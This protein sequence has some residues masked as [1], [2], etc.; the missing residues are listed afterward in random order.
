MVACSNVYL[1]IANH[2]LNNQS[3]VTEIIHT[4]PHGRNFFKY[5]T[6][7]WKIQLSFMHLLHFWAYR[8]LSIMPKILQI[9]VRIQMQTFGFFGLPL[10]VGHLFQSEY[11][12]YNSLFHFW[13]T[14]LPLLGNLEKNSKMVRAIP[15]GWSIFIRKCCSIFLMYSQWSLTSWFAIIKWLW[16]LRTTCTLT[17]PIAPLM[18]WMLWRCTLV[19]F[20]SGS[21]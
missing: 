4:P 17:L 12:N 21:L 8:V 20:I 15:I 11:S 3:V 14:T 19:L 10:D 6:P 5:T 18:L 1:L 16:R 13:Q 7:L 2:W 9:P